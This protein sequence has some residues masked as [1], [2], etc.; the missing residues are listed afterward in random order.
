MLSASP[1]STCAPEEP[2]APNAN[3]QNCNRAEAVFEL[4]RISSSA[5]SRSSGLLLSSSTSSALTMAP[6]GLIRSWQTFEHNSAAS[7]RLSGAGPDDD[8]PDIMLFLGFFQNHPPTACGAW[9]TLTNHDGL[10]RLIHCGA[11]RRHR[12]RGFAN[13]PESR[14]PK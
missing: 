1:R 12:L 2:A 4:L 5:N 14:Q 6:T 10:W 11:A 8:V 3:R 9:R 7:S 13:S